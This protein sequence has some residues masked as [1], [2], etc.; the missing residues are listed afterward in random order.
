MAEATSREACIDRHR[1]YAIDISGRLSTMQRLR[2]GRMLAPVRAGESVLDVGCNSGYIV[3]FLPPSCT[4]AGVDVAEA[5]VEKARGRLARVDVAPAEA[6]PYPDRSVDVVV[7]GEILEHVHD[8]RVVLLEARRV[9]RRLVVGSTPHERGQWGPRGK[10]AP[11]Q[12]RF[13]VR[14]FTAAT[15][16]QALEGAGLVDVALE[17]IAERG[18]PAVYVFRGVNP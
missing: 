9:A 2:I 17:E 15:L 12:H 3:D 6:L 1:A 13:H 10:R 14:C 11:D 7:L 16:R 4:V 5:L 18:A 8:P